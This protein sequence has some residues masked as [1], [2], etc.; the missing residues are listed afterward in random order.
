[1]FLAGLAGVVGPMSLL[2]GY[3]GMN[4]QELS[5]DT[6]GSLFGF[7]QIGIPILLITSISVIIVG[8]WAL[9][10]PKKATK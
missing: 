8:I 4:V 5:P 6:T 1:M 3:Y 10:V 2:T 9:T 7:W